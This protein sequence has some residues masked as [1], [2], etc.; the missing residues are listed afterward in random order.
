[1]VILAF[2]FSLQMRLAW[3]KPALGPIFLPSKHHVFL[4]SDTSFSLANLI[5]Y[6][7]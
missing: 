5:Y 2:W 7:F 3:Q 6:I 4:E 1:L